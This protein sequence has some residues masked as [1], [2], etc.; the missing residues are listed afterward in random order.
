MQSE[1]VFHLLVVGRY[2]DGTCSCTLELKGA[3]EEQ[4]PMG[5]FTR[6][7]RK[8][9]FKPLGYEIDECLSSNRGSGLKRDL[10]SPQLHCPF[11]NF[12]C[13]FPVME[14]FPNTV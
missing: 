10:V 13:C 8:L 3:V 4:F 6:R 9:D 14:N 1:N 12:A 7:G 5:E 2:Y 11:G